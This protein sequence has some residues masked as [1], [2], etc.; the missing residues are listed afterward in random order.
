ME[1]WLKSFCEKPLNKSILEHCL[2]V[3]ERIALNGKS[4]TF[5]YLNVLR[6]IQDFG[7]PQFL[8]GAEPYKSLDGAGA[9]DQKFKFFPDVLYE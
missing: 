4:F 7:Q 3:R 6:I 2:W 9:M 5:G 1:I 8:I